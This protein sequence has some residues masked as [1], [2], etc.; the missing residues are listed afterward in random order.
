MMYAGDVQIQSSRS[1][2]DIFADA[3]KS[4]SRSDSGAHVYLWDQAKAA[5]ISDSDDRSLLTI[6]SDD[7]I[8][9]LSLISTDPQ[10]QI[11][12]GT[13]GAAST[14]VTPLSPVT[15]T[16]LSATANG[17]GF[18]AP[19]RESTIPS[20]T[21]QSPKDWAEF[22][23]AGF[24]EITI[25]ENFA[26]TLLDKDEVAESP[27]QRN[28]SKR[29][30]NRSTVS[31]E[32]SVE[33]NS[34][35]PQPDAAPEPET[36]KFFLAATE[37]VQLD[38]AFIDFWRDAV[39]DPI[40]HDW[41]KFVVG[42]LKH[43]LTPHPTSTS[44]EGEVSHASSISWIIIEE[45]LRRPTPPPTP[46]IPHEASSGGLKVGAMP[47]KRAP[48]P[49]PSFGD[50]K[51]S[52]SATFKRFTLFGSSKDDLVEDVDPTASGSDKK[53]S[54]GRKKKGGASKS[55][56]IGEMGEV[57]SEEPEPQ[58]EVAEKVDEPKKLERTEETEEEE[59]KA[60]PHPPTEGNVDSIELL[61]CN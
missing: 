7:T 37:I 35:T 26:S 5:A 22:S 24:G 14:L 40:S 19:V 55:P 47:L 25:S 59:D 57:L 45:K 56:D 20:S 48:S 60:A 51:S 58:P 49:R 41:P 6:L 52:L 10:E 61:T 27:V 18:S 32:T 36:P 50:K 29:K 34:A 28:S 11:L 42:E 33:F 1:P 46:I 21:P 2:V 44:S 38:E 8:N 9:L 4:E 3:L 16:P 53:D 39:A 17:N 23:S 12:L 15:E 43:P 31:A 54:L 13:S 30:Q